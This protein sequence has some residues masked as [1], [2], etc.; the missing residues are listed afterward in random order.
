M[1]SEASQLGSNSASKPKNTV[2][3]LE[4]ILTSAAKTGVA[5]GSAMAI[6]VFSLMWMRTT[7]NYQFKNGGAFLETLKK[8]YSEGGL[9]RFYRG[10]VPA[11]VIGPISRF[12]DTATNMLA[13]TYFANSPTLKHFPIFVQTSL[14][15]IMAGLWRLSTL[16]VDA[17]KTSKQVYGD[18]GLKI[19]IN[20]FKIHGISAF[21]QGGVASALATMVGHYPW[22]VTNN[23][24][25]QYLA[26]Y[27]YDNE[28]LK[29]ILRSAGIGLVSTV[30][31]DCVS[32]SI[33]V[34]KTTKQTAEKVVTYREVINEVIAKDGVS[35]LFLRGLK[36]KLMTNVIQGVTFSVLWKYFQHEL[37]RH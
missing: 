25:E 17:W 15:S 5:G 8:L 12:G 27:S 16:P 6:Q 28:F 21:Y 33:R 30:V 35:G 10:I 13:T 36:T 32:N 9:I 31:S 3:T 22:Y 23:Y 24:L 34:I 1:S 19:I 26:R 4:Q 20:K 11:L 37:Q 7:M 29:A 2:K 14:G 18:G